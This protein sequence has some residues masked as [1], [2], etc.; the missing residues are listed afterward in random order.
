MINQQ[1][2]WTIAPTEQVFGFNITVFTG[3][4]IIMFFL[5][6]MRGFKSMINLIDLIVNKTIK[7]FLWRQ[8]K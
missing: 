8:R 1:M 6:S 7:K 2:L 4:M 5:T 3:Y